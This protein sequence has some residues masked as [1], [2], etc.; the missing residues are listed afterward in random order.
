MKFLLWIYFL[1]FCFLWKVYVCFCVDHE[2]WWWC[3]GLWCDGQ[4]QWPG[5]TIN[6]QE[7]RLW[8]RSSSGS[9]EWPGQPPAP[10]LSL[11][12]SSSELRMFALSLGSGKVNKTEI[13]IVNIDI[14]AAQRGEVE[15]NCSEQSRPYTIAVT[16]PEC[17]E[18]R[19]V[20][21]VR[22]MRQPGPGCESLMS[23]CRGRGQRLSG[24]LRPPPPPPDSGLSLS[25]M[26]NY[27]PRATRAGWS[28]IRSAGTS[29]CHHSQLSWLRPKHWF[30]WKCGCDGNSSFALSWIVRINITRGLFCCFHWSNW[31]LSA[32]HQNYLETTG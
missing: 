31:L 24:D 32:R 20:C 13:I 11:S 30:Y 27:H 5:T 29:A 8:P 23:W 4:D 19:G 1:L 15:W 22:V 6:C 3:A 7:T 25:D 16:I 17:W 9:S 12:A 2:T 14:G 28:V 21:W 10:A 26:G 18:W